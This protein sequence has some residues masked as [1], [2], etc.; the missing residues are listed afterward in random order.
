MIEESCL[1]ER[2][3]EMHH[4]D[5]LLAMGAHNIGEK[6]LR[7]IMLFNNREECEDLILN[8]IYSEGGACCCGKCVIAAM[9]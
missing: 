1:L 5:L 4:N 3:K 6:G 7:A 9:K 2:I 8:K